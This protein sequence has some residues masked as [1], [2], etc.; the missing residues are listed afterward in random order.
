[1]KTIISVFFIAIQD[2]IFA[3]SIKPQISF[4]LEKGLIA[5]DYYDQ[6]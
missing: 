2:N 6:F 3:F 5:H 4:F 1:M